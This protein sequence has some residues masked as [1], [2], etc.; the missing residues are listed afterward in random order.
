M[1]DGSHAERKTDIRREQINL[2]VEVSEMLLSYHADVF[3]SQI[4][5]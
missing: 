4:K 5:D 3:R 1:V 2:T